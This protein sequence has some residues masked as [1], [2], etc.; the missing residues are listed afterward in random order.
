M[1]TDSSETPKM[2]IAVDHRIDLFTELLSASPVHPAAAERERA[3]DLK[4]VVFEGL[5]KAVENGVPKS[6]AAIWTDSDLGESILL[7]GR[8]MNLNTMMSVER[9][10][11]AEFRFEDALGFSERL[12]NLDVTYAAARVPYNPG[13]E[14][15]VN[16]AQQRKLRRLSE[17][18]RSS[19]P[20]LTLE[21]VMR[22]TQA[23]LDQSGSVAAWD[24]NIRPGLIVQAIRE[25]QDAGV[26]PDLWALRGIDN[27]AA[28][29]TATAQ[30]QVDDRKAGVLFTLGDDPSGEPDLDQD[31]INLAARTPGCRG[32]VI[33]PAIYAADLTAY[34][35]GE[36]E[37]DQ[38]AARIAE[39]Y[40]AAY[41]RY[42]DALRTSDV[43]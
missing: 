2:V 12:S 4:Q 36:I 3:A 7:R 19:G 29:A 1:P 8:G 20:R 40:N 11:V 24:E 22:P 16:E 17:I 37:R 13:E 5:L 35:A 15:Q 27:P 32:L 23:Q 39:R 6:Q 34:N 10:R 25:L 9:A 21:L 18:S 38:A 43:I 31:L 33:G 14:P 26:E 41:T 30:A 42:T 28:M